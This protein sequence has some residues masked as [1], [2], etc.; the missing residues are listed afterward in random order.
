MENDALDGNIT[1]VSQLSQG[2][3]NQLTQPQTALGQSCE[4]QKRDRG[5]ACS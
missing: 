2:E 1:A 5:A 4:Q 3:D